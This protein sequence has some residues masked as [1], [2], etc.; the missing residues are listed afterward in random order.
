ME[1]AI[2]Y[3]TNGFRVFPCRPNA[4]QPA[5]AHGCLDATTDLETIERWWSETPEANVA[6]ATDDLFVLDVDPAGRPWVGT[7]NY[8]DL[9]RGAMTTTPRGGMHY[10]FRQ[11]NG[12][13][14]HN[15]AGKVA[16]G[17]DTRA[18]GGYV[19]VPPSIVNGRPY[20]WLA[21][22]EGELPT[23]PPW[24]L[25]LLDVRAPIRDTVAEAIPEGSRNHVLARFAGYFRRS[26]MV[27]S[28]ILASLRVINQVRR[29]PPVDDAE[30]AQIAGSVARYEP[31]FIEQSLIMSHFDNNADDEPQPA[32][33]PAAAFPAECIDAMPAVLREAFDYVTD[34]AIKPQPALT[35]G[36]LLALFGAATGRK[37]RDDYD[38]RTNVMILGLAPSGSGKEHPRQINKQLMLTAGMEMVNGPERIGSHAG[39]IASV[40]HHPIRLFQLDEIGRLLATMR[41]PKASHLFNVGTVLM[42]LY[43]SANTIWTGDAYADLSKVK[44]INQPHVCVYGTSV[45]ESLYGG[46]SPENLTDGL[47][48]RLLVL[49][50]DDVPDRRKPITTGIPFRVTETLRAWYEFRP[51]G[52]G[53]LD[54]GEPIVVEKTAD[55]DARHEEYCDAVNSRHRDESNID[56]AVWSRAP[57]KAAKLALIF[58]CAESVD[59]APR[60]TLDA[61]NWGIRLANYSTRLV[62]QAARNAIAGSEYESDLKFVFGCVRGEISQRELTR[63]TQRLKQRERQEILADLQSSGAIEIV[64]VA[65][66][67]KPKTVIRKRRNTL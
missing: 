27:E 24:L 47:V 15:T 39:I 25:E 45:P 21:E 66:A 42:Q 7:V 26:G 5:T 8:D 63:R 1:A 58:A 43:S 6:I 28:E 9:M 54:H 3:A 14:L 38:T 60:I 18:N 62:L 53:N 49:Q 29:R 10:W 11:T 35:L 13:D 59:L 16:V 40:A 37:V 12:Q 55:A 67:T 61:V 51:N 22:L 32:E 2:D 30:L 33:E 31:D 57:E 46:L 36:A 23:I 19:L 17:V 41:D 20:T 4:K 52:G 50:S 44:T 65:T 48:G 56:A 64:Q 34:T